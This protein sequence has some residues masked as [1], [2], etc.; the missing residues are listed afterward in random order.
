M[1]ARVFLVEAASGRQPEE[2]SVEVW[3]CCVE[4]ASGM[5]TERQEAESPICVVFLPSFSK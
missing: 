2:E 3:K 1:L 5:P 4:L